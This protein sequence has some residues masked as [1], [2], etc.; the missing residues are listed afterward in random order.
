ML[1]VVNFLSMNTSNFYTSDTWAGIAFF[2]IFFIKFKT[3][4]FLYLKCLLGT[5]FYYK[6][7]SSAWLFT[8]F[9]SNWGLN[10]AV[11]PL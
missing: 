5:F 4:Y 8:K 9:P 11:G 10:F 3:N 1:N 6:E 2:T 7:R